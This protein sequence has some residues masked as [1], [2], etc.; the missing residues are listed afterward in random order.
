M[1]FSNIGNNPKNCVKAGALGVC[2]T[3]GASV[4]VS[5]KRNNRTVTVT[6]KK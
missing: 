3:V 4:A 6:V 2:V 1:L 5:Q